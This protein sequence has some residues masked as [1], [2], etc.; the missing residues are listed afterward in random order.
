MLAKRKRSITGEIKLSEANLNID[1]LSNPTLTKKKKTS[2]WKIFKSEALFTIG[3]TPIIWQIIFFYI[4]LLIL[5]ATSLV[6]TSTSGQFIGLTLEHFYPLLNTT[7]LTIIFNSFGLS[8]VTTF[9]CLII[10]FPLA[11]FIAFNGGRLKNVLL[12]LLLIPFWTNFILHIYAWFFV[13][14]K[15]G[16]LNNLLLDLGLISSPLHFLNSTFSVLV[17]MVYFYL[18]FMVLPIFSSLERFNPLLLEASYDLGANH[19]QTLQKILL[20]LTL[21]AIRAGIFLVYIPSFGEF[22][23]PELMGGDRN[24]FVGNVISLFILGEK[25]GP[26]GIAFTVLSTLCLLI[27][28]FFINRFF[29]YLSKKITGEA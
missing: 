27:S 23:I 11:Y 21:S 17:M 20:P 18:P 25:T 12:F 9:L 1:K 29:Q 28:L 13:L 24:F 3:S 6:K 16:F 10:G 26:V 2:L 19:R 14:E 15:H 8:L 22:V 4:P 7:Y 5:V